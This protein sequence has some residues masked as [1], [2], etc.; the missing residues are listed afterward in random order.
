MQGLP[1]EQPGALRR[2]EADG[3]GRALSDGAS[4][5]RR[6]SA[7]RPSARASRTAAVAQPTKSGFG[8]RMGK[9]PRRQQH[10]RREKSSQQNGHGQRRPEPVALPSGAGTARKAYRPKSITPRRSST[11]RTEPMTALGLEPRP[12]DPARL[13]ELAKPRLTSGVF[14]Y[15][16]R[17]TGFSAD[18]N[19]L[20]FLVEPLYGKYPN[21]GVRE[22]DAERGGRRA[23]TARLVRRSRKVCR[24]RLSF[25][26]QDPDVL[27]EFIKQADGSAGCCAC[28]TKVSEWRPIPSMRT[29]FAPEQRSAPSP[30][31]TKEFIDE[32]GHPRISRAGRFGVGAFA[33][34][35]LGD[36]SECELA[37]SA[38]TPPMVTQSNAP[39]IVRLLK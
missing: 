34:F 22:L 6:L 21:V 36:S 1:G 31:W 13:F 33:I 28:A 27:V 39:G 2:A 17:R 24:T 23:R 25:Q 26:E 11:R 8:P 18:P 37:T 12:G 29:S 4:A 3:N 5:G 10:R 7:D 16:P 15:V 32:S 19:L 14:P 35:L 9:A 30:E 38:L 20:N